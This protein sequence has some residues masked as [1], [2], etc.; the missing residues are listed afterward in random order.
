MEATLNPASSATD[1]TVVASR[2]N[3]YPWSPLLFLGCCS[4]PWV[5]GLMAL[6]FLTL[7]QRAT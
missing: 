1:S 3:S 4:A 7:S 2:G 6:Q 5:W